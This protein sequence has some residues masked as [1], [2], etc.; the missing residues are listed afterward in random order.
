MIREYIVDKVFDEKR[1][2]LNAMKIADISCGCGGFLLTAA[3]EIR[4][5]SP[6]TYSDI[7]R[8]QLFG[9][10]IQDYSIT[11]TKLLLSLLALTDGED[12]EDFEFN[13][14]QEIGIVSCR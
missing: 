4:K 7:F 5:R 10:D 2:N 3:K 14:F 11:R 1:D 8:N 13:L 9:V 12:N 6:N